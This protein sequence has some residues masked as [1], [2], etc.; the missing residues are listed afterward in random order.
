M[1]HRRT[2]LDELIDRHGTRQQAAFFLHARGREI[3]EVEER[4]ALQQAAMTAVANA[5]PLDWR[6]GAVERADLA[7]FAFGPEDVVVAVGQDGLVANAAK[8]LSGQPVVGINPEPRRNPGVLVPHPAEATSGLLAAAVSVEVDT[9][10]RTKVMVMATVDDGQ[11]RRALNEIYVGHPSHQSSAIGSRH[12]LA[13]PSG[14]RR[15]GSS[16]ARAPG[17]QVGVDRSPSSA[18][19]RSRS[20][21]P[22]NQH[23]AGSCA[24][25]GLH[26]PPAPSSPTA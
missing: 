17:L 24:R 23:C 22:R 8:Y 1:V 13:R 26:Q 16:L 6:R 19:A 18:T 14:S 5:I 3:S 25:H 20:P 4:H 21:R 9:R 11:V 15:R 2:E 7:R 10:V 12:P